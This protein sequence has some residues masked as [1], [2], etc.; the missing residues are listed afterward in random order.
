MNAIDKI[1]IKNANQW[2]IGLLDANPVQ[3][4]FEMPRFSIWAI[5]N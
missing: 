3:N 2:L 1:R 4:K 5:S